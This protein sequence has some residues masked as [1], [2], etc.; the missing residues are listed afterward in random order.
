MAELESEVLK[1]QGL[2]LEA[3][4]IGQNLTAFT[5]AEAWIPSSQML[6]RLLGN[7]FVDLLAWFF[8]RLFG[9][10]KMW[11]LHPDSFDQENIKEI[12][13]WVLCFGQQCQ[14]HICAERRWMEEPWQHVRM[15]QSTIRL[16]KCL[17]K[18][19]APIHL[20]REFLPSMGL[21][22]AELMITHP[23][24][25]SRSWTCG[26]AARKSQKQVWIYDSQL[27]IFWVLQCSP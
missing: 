11:L 23:F 7:R 2:D 21:T 17:E 14:T 19:G 15:L 12:K 3:G 22:N 8:C 10:H 13:P 4:K 26:G 5:L 1:R 18:E 25:S 6:W 24:A 9:D 27:E 20:L 16:C